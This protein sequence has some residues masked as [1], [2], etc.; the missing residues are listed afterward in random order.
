MQKIISLAVLSIVCIVTSHCQT[1]SVLNSR[2]LYDSN[3]NLS[4]NQTDYTSV[5]A[6][7]TAFNNARR[8]EESQF[9]L[10]TNSISNLTMPNQ[11][12]WNSMNSDERFLFLANAERTSRAGLNYCQGDGPVQGLAFTGIESNIDN[13]AQTYAQF[14]ISTQNIGTPVSQASNIDANSNIG[15]SGCDGT[16]NT[17][18]DCCHSFVPYSV[19]RI[20]FQNDDTPSNP[21]TITTLGIEARSVY[22]CVYGNG[23][24]GNGR[25]MLLLQDVEQGGTASNPCGFNDDYGDSGDEGFLGLG[26][27]GGIPHSSLNATHIDM[28]VI[29]YFDPLPQSNDCNYNCTT[30]DPC[31]SN[32]SLNSNQLASGNFQASNFI[33]TTSTIPSSNTVTLQSG[34]T[35]ELNSSFEVKSGGVFSALIDGCYFALD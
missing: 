4:G 15:G 22:F 34:G 21:N 6:I 30:C 31:L 3:I 5:G 9:C 19:Y 29:S 32:V 27:A 12:T 23:S 11:S 2:I 26:I 35:I 25:R 16:K 33:S 14:L 28:V 13:I 7:E 8:G 10:P 20:F 24:L 17:K 18:P 1:P